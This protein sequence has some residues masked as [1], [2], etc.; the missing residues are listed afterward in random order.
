[1]GFNQK[2][3]ERT[4]VDVG[5]SHVFFEGAEINRPSFPDAS[6]QVVRGTFDTDVH[7]ISLQLN[8]HF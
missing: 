7:I 6:L 4:S 5:Y 3:G 1:V 8:H 2:L